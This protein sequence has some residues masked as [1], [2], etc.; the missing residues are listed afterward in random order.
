M[1]SAIAEEV[2]EEDDDATNLLLSP[3]LSGS[4]IKFEKLSVSNISKG[5]SSILGKSSTVVEKSRET[6]SLEV[7]TPESSEIKEWK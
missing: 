2:M 4:S 6:H 1:R 3:N 7:K 5:S